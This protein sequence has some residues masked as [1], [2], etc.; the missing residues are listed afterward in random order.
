[1]SYDPA[2]ITLAEHFL[3]TTAP[4]RLKSELAQAVQDCVENWLESEARHIK[5]ELHKKPS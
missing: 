2:C 1:M 5:D 3:P 4:D